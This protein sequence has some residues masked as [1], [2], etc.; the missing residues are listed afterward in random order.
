MEEETGVESDTDFIKGSLND[1][2]ATRTAAVVSRVANLAGEAKP[3]IAVQGDSPGAGL[4]SFDK[5]SSLPVLIDAFW[6][7]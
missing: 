2:L 1:A 3:P 7:S 4:F 6:S 5:Y